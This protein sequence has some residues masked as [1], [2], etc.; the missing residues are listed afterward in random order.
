MFNEW[1]WFLKRST[2]D[3]YFEGWKKQSCLCLAKCRKCFKTCTKLTVWVFS[4][5]TMWLLFTW[6]LKES[7]RKELRR[8]EKFATAAN[9]NWD[10]GIVL[11]SVQSWKSG[12]KTYLCKT[13][14]ELCMFLTFGHVK[15]TF[16]QFLFNIYLC[17][18]FKYFTQY[19]IRSH[20]FQVSSEASKAIKTWKIFT[21]MTKYLSQKGEPQKEEI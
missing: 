13:M 12:R 11:C 18:L 7:S 17:R 15:I 21:S 3:R 10:G 9:G 4:H 16:L 1:L 14:I 8:M 2:K 20:S 19:L 5:R 6:L